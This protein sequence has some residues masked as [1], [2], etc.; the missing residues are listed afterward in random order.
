MFVFIDRKLVVDLGGVHAEH[1]GNIELDTLDLTVGDNYELQIFHAERQCCGSNFKAETTILVGDTETC[2][3]QCFA[4]NGQGV[5]NIGTGKCMCCDGWSGIDCN[6]VGNSADAAGDVYDEEGA[7]NG[8][9]EEDQVV[10]PMAKYVADHYC[11]DTVPDSSDSQV[12]SGEATPAPVGNWRDKC[13]VPITTLTSTTRT[14]TFTTSSTSTV[15]TTTVSTTTEST[16]T[17]STTTLTPPPI[18]PAVP[19]DCDRHGAPIQVLQRGKGGFEVRQLDV[20]DGTY[21]LMYTLPFTATTPAYKQLNGVGINPVDSYAYGMMMINDVIDGLK[22]SEGGYTQYLVRFSDGQVDF[23]AKLPVWS[24]TATIDANGAYHYLDNSQMTLYTVSNIAEMPAYE[25]PNDA[26]LLDLTADQ[27]SHSIGAWGA[28]F[29]II[30]DLTPIR[31]DFEGKGTDSEYVVGIGIG[32]AKFK[33]QKL[34]INVLVIN[35]AT[36]QDWVIRIVATD[37]PTQ[38]TQNAIVVAQGN[39][40][41]GASWTYDGRILFAANSGAGVFNVEIANVQKAPMSGANV[42]Y[43]GPSAVTE[44]NDGMNCLTAKNPYA[45]CGFKDT[46]GKADAAV[47]GSNPVTDE[48]CGEGYYYDTSRSNRLCHA[49]TCT[50]ANGGVDRETCCTRVTTTATAT[51]TTATTLYATCAAKD[52]GPT[53]GPNAKNNPVTDDECGAGYFYN[54][55]DGLCSSERCAVADGGKDHDTCCTKVTLTA[56][57]TTSTPFL[58]DDDDASGSL[59]VGDMCV[60][61]D[62]DFSFAWGAP[63][64]APIPEDTAVGVV[65]GTIPTP[66]FRGVPVENVVF[67]LKTPSGRMQRMYARAHCATMCT[68]PHTI[69]QH[70]YCATCAQT[71]LPATISDKQRLCPSTCASKVADGVC[72]AECNTD[73]CDFDGGDCEGARG[74][75]AE[76]APSFAVD[77][78]TGDVSV[79]APLDW[80]TA[81]SH[82]FTVG[83]YVALPEGT[84]LEPQVAITVDIAAVPCPA[85]A[86]STT[87]TFPCSAYAECA[88]GADVELVAPTSTTDRVC[89]LS[90]TNV[91]GK[92]GANPGSDTSAAQDQEPVAA[93]VASGGIVGGIVAALAI[94]LLLVGILYKRKGQEEQDST[95]EME[96]KGGRTMNA[97]GA[98]GGPGRDASGVADYAVANGQVAGEY[99]DSAAIAARAAADTDE[100]TYDMA[101]SAKAEA[102]YAMAAGNAGEQTYDMAASKAEAVYAMG[103][104]NA[105]DAEDLYSVATAVGGMASKE[106]VYDLGGN[107]GSAGADPVYELGSEANM[108]DWGSAAG[109]SPD[110]VYEFGAAGGNPDVVYELGSEGVGPTYAVGAAADEQYGIPVPLLAGGYGAPQDQVATYDVA[111]TEDG[112]AG[113]TEPRYG[114]AH[115][116]AVGG[117]TP[118]ATYDVAA[119]QEGSVRGRGGSRTRVGSAGSIGGSIG[120]AQGMDPRRGSFG[121]ANYALA[122][123][124]SPS[125]LLQR[126]LSETGRSSSYGAALNDVGAP[127]DPDELL[128]ARAQ[129]LAMEAGDGAVGRSSSYGTALNDVGAP[130][131]HDELLSARAQLLAMEAGDGAEADAASPAEDNGYMATGPGVDASSTGSSFT[132]REFKVQ[133]R[134]NDLKFVSV[135]RQNPAFIDIR[136]RGEEDV[137]TDGL[138]LSNIRQASEDA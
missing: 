91:G 101:A 118:A 117:D 80:E 78:T 6:T 13:P 96:M 114:S 3:N 74:R 57:T 12:D 36:K 110:P 23:L 2:P 94:I 14:R 136:G 53:P 75:R 87:G 52:A 9:N 125:Q 100:Q 126:P 24:Y 17:E 54:G 22:Y 124:M 5:C 62:G 95:D 65:V 15:S 49:D 50:V 93:K 27:P 21:S 85:V 97:A 29:G 30:A 102:T 130:T 51:T 83:L 137:D 43:V 44:N 128:A 48:E 63:A 81:P 8:S 113:P 68:N 35:V 28:G 120:S 61:G 84:V 7:Y 115:T 11:W 131:D 69:G 133:P 103:S 138:D 38:L 134:D 129:L 86:F 98:F 72:D 64:L 90:K 89:T 66:T 76:T 112:A 119:T 25:L 109:G 60:D 59:C 116:V 132:S 18:V 1:S 121:E 10:A 26:N 33:G 88:G 19:F 70:L 58:D 107:V 92:D 47:P 31:T 32:F 40:A 55:G 77:A 108:T 45:T 4:P 73:E 16:T 20:A 41:F 127:T 106:A 56:S 111:A 67:T 46:T 39:D 123:A 37:V 135:K 71:H 105:D 34:G 104:S 42:Y 82:T 122:A 79:A 99:M